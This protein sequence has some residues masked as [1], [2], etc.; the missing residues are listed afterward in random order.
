MLSE[1]IRTYLVSYSQLAALIG[2]RFYPMVLPQTPTLPAM[3]WARI[4]GPRE[5]SHSGDSQLAFSRYQFTSWSA[6]LAEARQVAQALI[7]AMSG[8]SGP[9]GN[10]IV[11]AAFVE[12]DIDD[13]DQ[14]TGL[15]S[16]IVDVTMWA[17]E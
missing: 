9:M 13:Y 8:Y 3:V 14:E 10:E 15:Y 16:V 1:G 2:A 6:D 4:S 12:N 5:Y 7:S 11:Y 17:K